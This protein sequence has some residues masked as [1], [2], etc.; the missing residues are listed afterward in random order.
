MV[1]AKE[2]F[3]SY[4]KKFEEFQENNEEYLQDIK[5]DLRNGFEPLL[6]SKLNGTQNELSNELSHFIEKKVGLLAEKEILTDLKISQGVGDIQKILDKLEQFKS[7]LLSSHRSF[8]DMVIHGPENMAEV[9]LIESATTFLEPHEL[10]SAVRENAPASS[11][12]GK[13]EDS[14]RMKDNKQFSITHQE[15]VMEMQKAQLEQAKNMK[16]EVASLGQ[17]FGVLDTMAKGM[18]HTDKVVSREALPDVSQ[19]FQGINL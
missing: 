2:E 17:E 4:F 11:V 3:Y 9:S 10:H 5:D 15:K 12:L 18:K 7:N 6:N 8:K 16:E 19:K 1:V 13:I 14:K